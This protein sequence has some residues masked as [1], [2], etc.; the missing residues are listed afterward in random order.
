MAVEAKAENS[1]R[2]F[3]VFA[4][5]WP[6]HDCLRVSLHY[7]SWPVFSVGELAVATRS[8]AA[9]LAGM[10]KQEELVEM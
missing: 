4:F 10:E 8:V 6:T 2:R 1:S 3:A 9:M 7:R 5:F